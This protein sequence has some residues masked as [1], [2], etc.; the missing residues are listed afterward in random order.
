M[1][2]LVFEPTILVFELAKTI[3]ALDRAAAVVG[4]GILG[5]YET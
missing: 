3:H 2:R 5:F 4:H 1:P